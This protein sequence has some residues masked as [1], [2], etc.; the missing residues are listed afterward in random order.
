M[1]RRGFL[2]ALAG[3]AVALSAGGIALIEAEP[4]Q[5][6]YFLPP[7]GG[8][9]AGSWEL[10]CAQEALRIVNE[11]IQ[12]SVAEA[13]FDFVA[14]GSCVIDLARMQSLA[15]RRARLIERVD[16][17]ARGWTGYSASYRTLDSGQ[18]IK[19]HGGRPI[20][21]AGQEAPRLRFIP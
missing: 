12:G 21:K 2:K 11:R 3:G 17:L 14:L 6:A 10:A 9:H 13:R 5:R 15:D 7:R 19:V 16:K 4:I 20:L 8:W 18:V 1:N